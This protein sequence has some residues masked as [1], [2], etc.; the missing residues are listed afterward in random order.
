MIGIP[1]INPLVARAQ[2]GTV[3]PDMSRGPV[4]DRHAGY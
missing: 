4:R 1:G 3:G 2:F